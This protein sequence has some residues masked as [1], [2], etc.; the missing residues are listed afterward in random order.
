MAT[1]GAKGL[2]G[3]SRPAEKEANPYVP[4]PWDF[5]GSSYKDPIR[6]SL[7]KHE[8]TPDVPHKQRVPASR[9]TMD[10]IDPAKPTLQNMGSPESMLVHLEDISGPWQLHGSQ[11]KEGR[12]ERGC[13]YLQGL[14][15]ISPARPLPRWL[16][17]IHMHFSNL[18]REACKPFYDHRNPSEPGTVEGVRRL[19]HQIQQADLENTQQNWEFR[20][21]LAVK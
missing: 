1:S 5:M 4:E 10:S 19:S 6:P 16:R 11:Q 13:S 20:K 14:L 18:H 3:L 15:V 9:F 12:L 21:R 8:K 17:I 2:H 7:D